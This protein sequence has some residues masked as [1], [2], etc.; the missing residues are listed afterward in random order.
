M[1]KDLGSNLDPAVSHNFLEKVIYFIFDSTVWLNL[2][3]SCDRSDVFNIFLLSLHLLCKEM[4]VF[5]NQLTEDHCL[6]SWSEAKTCILHNNSFYFISNCSFT[7]Y[8]RMWCSHKLHSNLTRQINKTEIPPVKTCKRPWTKPDFCFS[9]CQ[10][11]ANYASH[12]DHS[13]PVYLQKH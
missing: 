12:A 10:L 4:T 1:T 5:E 3:L 7:P 13:P 6:L 11:D 2:Q 9:F 8:H